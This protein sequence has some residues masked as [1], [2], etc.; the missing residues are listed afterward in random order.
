[1]S[2]FAQNEEFNQ[3]IGGLAQN[4]GVSTNLIL[5]LLITILLWSMVWKLSG[6]WKSARKGSLIWFIVLAL[7]NTV[8]ILPILYIYVFS[9]IDWN[10]FVKVEVKKSK[11]KRKKV[12]VKKK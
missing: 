10:K 2:L 4:F 7:T 8:G 12:K 1:M 6:M 11:P 3:F 5:M 9:K